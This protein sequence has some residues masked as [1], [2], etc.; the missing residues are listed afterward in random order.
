MT[1]IAKGKSVLSG[2]TPLIAGAAA[3]LLIVSAGMFVM[4]G[5][6]EAETGKDT[7]KQEASAEEQPMLKLGNPVVALVDGEEIKRSDVFT[8]IGGLPEQVRQMPIQNLFPLALE[9]VINNRVI[10]EKAKGSKLESDPEV[11]KMFMQAK[12]QIVRNVFVE[13]QVTAE[14]S[15]KKLLKAY[16]DLLTQL[17]DVQETHAR[18]ILV[19]SEEKAKEVV[20]K[21]DGGAKFEDLVNEYS[22]GPS[23]ENGG[24]LGYFAKNEMVPEFGEAAFALDVGK[25]TKDPVKTQFGWHIIKVEDRRKRPEPK[26]EEVKPQLEQQLRQQILADLLQKWQKD[27]KI[28]KFDMNGEPVKS[29]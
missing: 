12:G 21:L 7:P 9:Q 1:E 13:R 3:L 27:A 15:Q 29:N 11:E 23:K 4:S 19:D 18:H 17:E 16:E 2:K 14:V 28:K 25:Y 26:F 10:S 22:S 5:N 6:G 8:F 20:G 24:D